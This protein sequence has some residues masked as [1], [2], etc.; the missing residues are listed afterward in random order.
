MLAGE[1]ESSMLR[2]GQIMTSHVVSMQTHSTALEAL[3]PLDQRASA[4]PHTVI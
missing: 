4:H 2:A 1:K 3:N